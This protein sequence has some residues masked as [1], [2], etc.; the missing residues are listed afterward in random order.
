MYKRQGYLKGF[1]QGGKEV[2]SDRVG[3][4]EVTIEDGEVTDLGTMEM[5]IE[6]LMP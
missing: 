4:V 2:E 6:D 5:K 1:S 3:A